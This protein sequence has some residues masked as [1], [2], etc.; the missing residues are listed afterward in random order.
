MDGIILMK[1][2]FAE[3]KVNILPF[4]NGIITIEKRHICDEMVFAF[5]RIIMSEITYSPAEK[6]NRKQRYENWRTAIG[7]QAVDNLTPSKYL[8][9]LAEEHIEGKKT[10]E[11]VE[12]LIAEYYKD[13]EGKN[14]A[15][16]E[17]KEEADI[18]SARITKLLD[19]RT[20]TLTEN[21]LKAIHKNLFAGFK[22]YTPGKYR[23]HDIIKKEWVLDSDTVQYGHW[24]MLE[25]EIALLIN[26]EQ[27]FDYSA[28]PA[29]KQ[30]SHIADFISQVWVQHAFLEGNTRT[31]AV[32]A[33]KYLRSIGFDVDNKPFDEHARYFRNALVRANYRNGVRKIEKDSKYLF[34][35][36]ENQLLQGKH[37]LRNRE[38]HVLWTDETREVSPGVF[39]L[40]AEN[41]GI[42]DGVN[43]GVNDGVKLTV[44]ERIVFEEIVKNNHISAMELSSI[45]KKSIRTVERTLKSL[46]EKRQITRVGADKNGHWLAEQ[47]G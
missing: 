24:D 11:D 25:D 33:I 37:D 43:D 39:R 40:P 18:V 21:S 34:W 12:T 10:I 8:L 17:R 44:T 5:E 14:A 2:F 35:F 19:T 45:T 36:F 30:V 16:E 4:V 31:T 23:K 42:S 38:I 32:F 29:E 46:K 27:H 22:E 6:A 47:E 1:S 3:G 28:L 15:K 13:G 9:A 20:F 26:Q 7:L 41:E